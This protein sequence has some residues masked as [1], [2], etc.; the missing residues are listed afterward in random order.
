MTT[1][2]LPLYGF[3]SDALASNAL[4]WFASSVA[5]WVIKNEPAAQSVLFAVGRVV[6]DGR[7]RAEY[8]FVL[9]EDR[10]PG[11][12]TVSSPKLNAM[13][14]DGRSKTAVTRAIRALYGCDEVD[15][16]HEPGQPFYRAFAR[17]ARDPR[18]AESPFASAFAPVTLFSRVAYEPESW[19]ARL[20]DFGIEPK[21]LAIVLSPECEEPAKK[22]VSDDPREVYNPLELLEMIQSG[23]EISYSIRRAEE[24][25]A[26][27]V[28][29]I[30]RPGDEALR[31]IRARLGVPEPDA[32]P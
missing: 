1:R 30:E 5:R 11:W 24:L 12:P 14:G 9:C 21:T 31:A 3:D 2:A 26:A 29:F 22:P 15:L 28:A 13:L 27:L 8:A 18:P 6:R 16:G 32:K 4:E 10:A 19:E 25:S 20:S 7:E 17:F 23:Q